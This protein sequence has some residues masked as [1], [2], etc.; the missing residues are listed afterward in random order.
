L[1]DNRLNRKLAFLLPGIMV[2]FLIVNIAAF[3]LEGLRTF[4]GGGNRHQLTS[5]KHR[6]PSWPGEVAEELQKMGLRRGDK[7][8]V[9]G[10]A[11]DSY[12]AR[13]ARL[14]IVAEMFGWEADPFWLG[15]PSFQA[16]IVD[17]FR[18]TGADAIVAEDVPSYAR[19]NGWRQI[20]DTNHFVYLFGDR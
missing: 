12:W 6:S 10:Y 11:F 18:S 17:A 5:E 4:S 15:S 9:I 20:K 8:A 16:G 19:L 2:L 7:T 13:L 3:N 14:S 1:P